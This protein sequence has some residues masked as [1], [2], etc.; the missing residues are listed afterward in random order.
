MNSKT[1]LLDKLIQ[2]EKKINKEL[3]SSGPYWEYKNRKT[4][5]E[6]KKKGLKNFRGTNSGIG[7][8]FS[9]NLILDVRNELGF[10]GRFIGK[11]FSFPLINYI[12]DLQLK[13]TNRHLKSFLESQKIIHQN[14]TEVKNLINKYKFYKTLDFGCIQSFEY[15]D[16]TYS[17]FYLNLADRIEKL[18]DTFNFK[19]IKSFFEIG[20]GFGANIH[21][22][23][24]NFP[25]I[26][27][28]LYLVRNKI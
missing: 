8:S 4:I 15:L 17:S 16:K 1:I 5:Y 7:S 12:F 9:D 19:N 24:T 3:Y 13:I 2:D 10:K 6:I 22:M 27:K 11:I 26:K 18:S 23:V 20:G 14:N 21:F 28:I 25:N